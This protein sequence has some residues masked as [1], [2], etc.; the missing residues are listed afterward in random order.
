LTCLG[1]HTL[2][3]DEGAPVKSEALQQLL[4]SHCVSL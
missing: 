2:T 3:I 4:C 1:C